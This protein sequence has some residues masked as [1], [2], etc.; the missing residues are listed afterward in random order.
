MDMLCTQGRIHAEKNNSGQ[1]IHP[2]L[3]QQTNRINFYPTGA[4][5]TNHLNS[6]SAEYQYD[7]SPCP[8]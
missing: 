4:N 6:E 8:G 2:A 5:K 7:L 3:E 1:E